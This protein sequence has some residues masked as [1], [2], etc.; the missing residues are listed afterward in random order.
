MKLGFF[1]LLQ[2]DVFF[3]IFDSIGFWVVGSLSS[4]ISSMSFSKTTVKYI[5]K[6]SKA[7]L[8]VCSNIYIFF[9]FLLE[10]FVDRL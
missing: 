4:T 10:I 9:K 2:S 8:H 3:F 6:T 5:S 7:F 1:A